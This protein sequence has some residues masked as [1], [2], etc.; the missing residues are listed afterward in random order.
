MDVDK[1]TTTLRDEPG[2]AQSGQKRLQQPAGIFLAPGRLR[3]SLHAMAL[4]KA[5]QGTAPYA[6][7]QKG[8]GTSS[9][10][11]QLSEPVKG[12]AGRPFLPVTSSRAVPLLAERPG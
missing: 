5:H 4:A 1:R 11:Y 2:G 8:A 6:R 7:C 10:L 3:L 12:P 9:L